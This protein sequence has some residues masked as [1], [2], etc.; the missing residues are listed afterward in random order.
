MNRKSMLMIGTTTVWLA[1]LSG[2]AISAQDKYSVKVP[3]GL[4]F[5]DQP[6]PDGAMM[7]KIEWLK[8]G[9]AHAAQHRLKPSIIRDQKTKPGT[10]KH[11][12][13]QSDRHQPLAG[14]VTFIFKR[15]RK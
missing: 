3:G 5:N 4:A 12:P 9:I 11:N 1:V 15:V 2:L 7:A 6:V 8:G 13:V 10:T 14:E